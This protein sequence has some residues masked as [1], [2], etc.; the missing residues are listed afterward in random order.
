MIRADTSRTCAGCPEIRDEPWAGER[1]IAHRCMAAGDCQGRVVGF[2]NIWNNLI[3]AWCSKR[4]DG[5]GLREP[6]RYESRGFVHPGA[7]DA[8]K[9]KAKSA[10]A[11][12]WR[13][14]REQLEAQKSK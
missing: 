3:P 11:A 14:L 13:A 4:A 5:G 10:A 2:D 8:P 7:M 6:E 1:Q 9:D 12:R